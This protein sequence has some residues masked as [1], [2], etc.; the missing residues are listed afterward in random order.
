MV[1]AAVLCAVTVDVKVAHEMVAYIDL[2][3]KLA[4]KA[5]EPTQ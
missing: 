3:A 4:D 5:E 2:M 1:A